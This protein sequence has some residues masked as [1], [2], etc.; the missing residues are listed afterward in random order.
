MALLDVS[1][2][3]FDPDFQQPYGTVM[4][5]TAVSSVGDNGIAVYTTAAPVALNC[6]IQPVVI[7]Q[8]LLPDLS[9]VEARIQVYTRTRLNTLTDTSPADL[10]TW[11][12]KTY[13]VMSVEDYSRFGGGYVRATCEMRNLQSAALGG[14]D[15]PP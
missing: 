4:L 8:S 1:D 2:V 15:D 3:L 12:G 5:I 9:R 6:V 14:P 11:Q 10:I 13:V 7:N